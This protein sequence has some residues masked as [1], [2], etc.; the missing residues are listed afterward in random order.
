MQNK[1]L[2]IFLLTFTIFSSFILFIM[3]VKANIDYTDYNYVYIHPDDSANV[4]TDYHERYGV[5]DFYTYDLYE[6]SLNPP[7]YSDPS[8]I[9]SHQQYGN[10]INYT[11]DRDLG[12]NT[13]NRKAL[14][15]MDHSVVDGCEFRYDYDNSSSTAPVFIDNMYNY[16]LVF[17]FKELD[18]DFKVKMRTSVYAT[19]TEYRFVLF[20]IE[21]H[22]ES[23]AVVNFYD[24]FSTIEDNF[25]IN[26]NSSEDNYYFIHFS[27]YNVTNEY[28]VEII[29]LNTMDKIN[30]TSNPFSYS[31]I[32][33][34]LITKL[35]P[36]GQFDMYLL[37]FDYTFN[38]N[39]LDYSIYRCMY[40]YLIESLTYYINE[41]TNIISS[42]LIKA[43]EGY[44]VSSQN[45]TYVALIMLEKLDYSSFSIRFTFIDG[46]YSDMILNPE[47]NTIYQTNY[48]FFSDRWTTL[49]IYSESLQRTNIS[50]R[51]KIRIGVTYEL[52]KMS[53][54]DYFSVKFTDVFPIVVIL[55]FVPAV[56]HERFRRIG[57]IF[58]FLLAIFLLM[59][60]DM[61]DQQ[62]GITLTIIAIIIIGLYINVK[63]KEEVKYGR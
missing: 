40:F 1:K 37:S 21:D 34:G 39:N 10:I 5:M 55:L 59:I 20:E 4:T 17:K 44:V 35:I 32:A 50:I 60:C 33:E 22:N 23:T 58:G 56:M 18:S 63:R 13:Y 15:M 3:P 49:N 8:G 38:Y 30:Y 6:T 46:E 25:T 7:A 11:E 19:T 47:Y 57:W 12:N 51:F 41:K 52:E 2:F 42:P 61:I 43:P 48:S 53:L 16:S 36:Y 62:T 54:Y 14:Y 31:M 45:V 9:D 24:S 26:Y 29:H 28:Y 27:F